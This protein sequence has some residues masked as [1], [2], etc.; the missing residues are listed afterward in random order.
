MMDLDMKPLHLNFVGDYLQDGTGKRRL[1]FRIR[2]ID[3]NISRLTVESMDGLALDDIL[4]SEGRISATLE[5]FEVVGTRCRVPR[6]LGAG[7]ASDTEALVDDL[8]LTRRL[9]TQ[10][11]D[12]SLPEGSGAYGCWVV[13][14][15]R[16][17]ARLIG[18]GGVNFDESE[19]Q[20][21]LLLNQ[22]RRETANPASG[23]AVDEYVLR[24][25]IVVEAD[26][27]GRSVADTLQLLGQGRRLVDVVSHVLAFYSRASVEWLS[28]EFGVKRVNGEKEWLRRAYRFRR[29]LS[30]PPIEDCGPWDDESVRRVRR[31][32]HLEAARL[33]GWSDHVL[34]AID[35]Y[36]SSFVLSAQSEF[37]ALTTSLEATKEA[38]LQATRGATVMEDGAWKA[39]TKTL[40]KTIREEITD[41]SVRESVYEKMAELN[42]P[43]YGRVVVRMVDRLGVDLADIY[44]DGLTFISMRNDIIHQGRMPDAAALAAETGRLRNLVERVIRAI[45]KMECSTISQPVKPEV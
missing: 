9:A 23:H 45:L 19:K 44:P 7:K 6:S 14:G 18:T 1:R 34:S 20:V 27:S 31:D 13:S 12:L 30:V 4:G 26:A 21:S 2:S 41:E 25:E 24:P 39:L 11:R 42:R 40:R 3:Y 15:S 29:V 32:L 22:D 10:G 33:L 43:A 5:D 8:T 38:F 28:E 36:V 35:A 17:L 37:L 16:F